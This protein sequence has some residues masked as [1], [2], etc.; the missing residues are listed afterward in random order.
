MI[1][2]LYYVTTQANPNSN[3][4]MLIAF[5]IH[6]NKPGALPPEGGIAVWQT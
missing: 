3:F 2:K 6:A 4:G 1:S 5:I